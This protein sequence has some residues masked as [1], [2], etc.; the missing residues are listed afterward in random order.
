M[1]ERSKKELRP[2]REAI[3]DAA[4]TLFAQKGYDETTIPEIAQAAGVAVGTV[5]LYFRNKYEVLTSVSVDLEATLA[6][7]FRDPA[8]LRLPFEQVPRA[9][10]EA[11]FRVGRQEKAYMTLLQINVASSEQISQQK[12]VNAQ[13]LTQTIETFLRNAIAEGRLAPCDTEMYA[14]LLHLLGQAV[15]HQCFAVEDGEREELYRQ[16]MIEF[17]ERLFFGPSLSEGERSQ[18]DHLP[19]GT[20]P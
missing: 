10:V 8:F 14:Q 3:L 1:P 4:R 12:K 20:M 19:D 2:K 18:V 7:V 13:Q 9:M 17:V 5:Y 16:T 6:Q 15:L 11:L